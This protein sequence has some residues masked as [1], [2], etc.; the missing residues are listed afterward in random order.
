M[1]IFK[2]AIVLLFA[3]FSVLLGESI[4]MNKLT[5]KLNTSNL[6]KYEEFKQLFAKQGSV[7]E[8]DASG[9]EGNRC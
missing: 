2:L 5:W 4:R 3:C 8:A 6:G 7:L 1:N 9:F